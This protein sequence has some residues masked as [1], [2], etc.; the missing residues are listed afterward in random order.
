MALPLDDFDMILGIEFF[1]QAKAMAM[2]H[3]GGIM[4]VSE[5]SPSFVL[6]EGHVIE[7]PLMQSV[8]QFKS[9]ITK[10]E[11]TMIATLVEIKPDQVV[12]VSD[13]VAE[14]WDEFRDVMPTKLPKVLSLW[15]AIDHRI[16]LVLGTRP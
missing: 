11:T 15:R 13:L 2:P 9:G 7:K 14:V 4:I 12:E 6:V 5:K 8:S 3:L 10:G 16:E 1:V